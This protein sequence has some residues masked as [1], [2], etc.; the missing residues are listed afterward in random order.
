M[1]LEKQV[2]SLKLAKKLKELGVGQGSYFVWYSAGVSGTL[3]ARFE[4]MPKRVIKNGEYQSYAA[5]TAA[6]LGEMLPKRFNCGENSFWEWRQKR[7]GNDF[8][9]YFDSYLGVPEEP[10]RK[11]FRAKTEGNARAEALIYLK[12]NNLWQM[13]E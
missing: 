13:A 12:K 2:C 11:F 7:V 4:R 3:R 8:E 1:K 9:V 6:E 10:S 5:F